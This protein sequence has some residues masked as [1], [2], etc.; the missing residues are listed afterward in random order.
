MRKIVTIIG[1]TFF[2]FLV[3]AQT[4]SKKELNYVPKNF[5]EALIQLDKIW[6]DS[7]KS[8]IKSMTEEKF[9]LD[10]FFLTGKNINYWMSN[11]HVFGL[12]ETA[13]DLKKDLQARGLSQFYTNNTLSSVIL[14]SFYRQLKDKDIQFEQQLKDINQWHINMLDPE[15]RERQNSVFLYNYMKQLNIGDTLTKN[16][17]YNRNRSGIPKK[18]TTIKV[19]VLEKS[20]KELKVEIVSFGTETNK[21]LIYEETGCSAV[22]CW[23]SLNSFQEVLRI[24]LGSSTGGPTVI[25]P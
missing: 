20:D 1:L 7:I 12:F 11:R 10:Y 16:V 22:G 4:L 15:W 2:C 8:Q 14:R 21:E 19:V 3:C 25:K 9:V 17:S 6:S 13:S 24:T 23:M 18:N 5:E